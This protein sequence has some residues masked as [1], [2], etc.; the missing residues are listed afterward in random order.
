MT[1]TARVSVF[2]LTALAAAL[3]GTAACNDSNAPSN[4]TT[5]AGGKA[6]GEGGAAAT[7]VGGATATGQ[8]GAATGQ[9]GAATGEGGATTAAGGATVTG[10]N[11][12][13]TSPPTPGG[14]AMCDGTVKKGAACTT[15]AAVCYK[16]CGPTNTGWKSE[17]CTAGVYVEVSAC[18][19]TGTDYSAF[20]VPATL[21]ELSATCPDTT[22]QAGQACTVEPCV[23]C[24][25]K[26]T[27]GYLD[28]SGAAKS[29]WCLC[30]GETDKKWTCGTAGTA[31]PCTAPGVGATGC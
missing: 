16:A 19:W 2:A 30:N 15:E 7:D 1:L 20:R 14:G 13:A 23:V 29:G 28:S 11:Y 26:S 17:T 5:S 6:S 25:D 22:P 3:F 21:A 8:G 9:G 18:T 31:W 12:P 24:A 27:G 10:C 4:E